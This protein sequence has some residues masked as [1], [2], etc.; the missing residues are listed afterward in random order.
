MSSSSPPKNPLQILQSVEFEESVG[1]NDPRFVDMELARGAPKTLDRLAR[2]FGFNIA[3]GDFYPP[4][5]RHTLLFGHIGCGKSTE[6][7]N[8]ASKL[9]AGHKL[10]VV[11]VDVSNELDRNNL[12]YADVLM[13]LA[14]GLME[15][16]QKDDIHLDE[17]ATV[18]LQ[19]WF[20]EHV[21]T[22]DRA[23]ELVAQLET[24]AETNT[25][26]PFFGKLFAKLTA[27]AKTNATYKD[28]L[29]SVIR[30]TFT[31]FASAF[32]DFLRKAE[33]ALKSKGKGERVLFI[34]DNSDKLSA[35][36]T[37]RF[38]IDD[39]ERLQSIEAL[40]LYTAPL[41]LKYDGI[42]LGK[43]DDIVLPVI[44]LRD[45]AGQLYMPGCQALRDM[46]LK[47]ADHAVFSDESLI[48]ELISYCGGHPRELLRLLKLCCEFSEGNLI[49]RNS[50]DAAIK[51]L[52]SDYRRF[53][54]PDDYALLVQM[55][56]ESEQHGGNNDRTRHLLYRLA[57]IEYNDGGWRRSHPAIRLLEGYHNAMLAA[58]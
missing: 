27:I 19:D 21:K 30:N 2:K 56:R 23:S 25:G 57:L 47:R 6:L 39:A 31:Q 52:S 13:A 49:D 51:S 7:L 3:K 40:M 35:E 11:T 43:L 55:D 17:N 58:I 24:G 10:Y 18:R 42:P 20:V 54:E 4:I 5:K 15:H 45:R 8:F 34:I 9:Q 28:S 29:R 26:V 22:E 14:K 12:Q 44:K 36:D 32:N 1:P 46:L 33:A 48:D 37:K 16:L 41:S 53:L 38:F 50:L